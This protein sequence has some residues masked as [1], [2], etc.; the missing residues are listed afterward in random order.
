MPR[1][2]RG[3]GEV[4]AEERPE[5]TARREPDDDD[6]PQNP[7]DP[8]SEGN[9]FANLDVR[10]PSR[11]P[12][13]KMAKKKSRAL[14]ILGIL[15][16]VGFVMLA[17]CCGGG[18]WAWHSITTKSWENYT[19]TTGGFSA[20]FPG[21]PKETTDTGGIHSFIVETNFGREAYGVMY[22][23]MDKIPGTTNV[24]E[25][26][27]TT[28]SVLGDVR[29]KKPIKLNGH[30]GLEVELDS[31]MS[32]TPMI[33][34]DRVYLV[35]GRLFQVMVTRAKDQG[36]P[37]E[38]QKFL[39]SFKLIG[40]Y[41]EAA[42]ANPHGE[43]NP[44]R[45]KP[46]GSA[47]G[48]FD[49][50][51]A[52]LD[53]Y[54]KALREGDVAAYK[55]YLVKDANALDG[56]ET[57]VSADTKDQSPAGK[58]AAGKNLLK[59]LYE[60]RWQPGKHKRFPAEI[61]GDKATIVSIW[62][63]QGVAG[64][65]DRFDKHEFS[66]IN[67]RWF[68]T[69]ESWGM[70]KNLDQN[71]YAWDKGAPP[72]EDGPAKETV[73]ALNKLGVSADADNGGNWTV[74]FGAETNLDQ[75]IPHADK[76]GRIVSVSLGENCTDAHLARVARWQD[77][78]TLFVY[79]SKLTNDGLKPLKDLKKL[80]DLHLSNNEG[81]SEASLVHVAGIGSLTGLFLDHMK[82]SEAGAKSLG[83][84]TKLTYLQINECLLNDAA[85][86]HL[87]S[88]ANLEDLDLAGNEIAGPGLSKLSGMKKL[89]RLALTRNRITDEGLKGLAGL[90]SL[91][92]LNIDCMEIGDE[93]LVHIA[94]LKDIAYLNL[95]S[96]NVKG[97]GFKHLAKLSRLSNV[98]LFNL[99]DLTGVGL[100][101][102]AACREMQDL[103][104]AHTGVT[105]EG[106]AHIKQL[107]Q[108]KSL[109]LP[110]YGLEFDGFWKDPHPERFSDAGLKHV[111]QM[112]WLESI[113][114]SGSGVTDAGLMEL[115]GLARLRYI[116]F[117]A[118]PTV[119][120]P[121]LVHLKGL[122]ELRDLN[123]YDTGVDDADLKHVAQLKQITTLTLPKNTTDAG[124]EHL[125]GMTQLEEVLVPEGVT[126]AG[127]EKLKKA[128]PK[129]HIEKSDE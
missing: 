24:E 93:G 52:A 80:S 68:Q 109:E 123:L 128:L 96:T 43:K 40:A 63:Y 87:A 38:F 7:A 95:S 77:L 53:A 33:I 90:T 70:A 124:L 84:N 8:R 3:T 92:S 75:A 17:L 23:D 46:A 19:S 73:A 81:L 107:Q 79:H 57:L 104:L 102:L 45:E 59:F 99:P 82:L 85:L 4:P 60:N 14:L 64:E 26:L 112:T 97:P 83:A 47:D 21:K 116:G 120:G 35:K 56:F 110:N 89:K 1:Q 125:K 114:F 71:K 127:V 115:S 9:D 22:N 61:S 126:K 62:E 42:P 72:G 119:K 103:N 117:G 51:D 101:H 31:P 98:S 13:K 18:Y 50:P 10:P 108:I 94:G 111:A 54:V 78:R 36:D 41:A 65:P 100:E 86:A 39:D 74:W 88:L 44:P 49:T 69:S 55:A 48:G 16:G 32:G 29:A 58:E 34:T 15:G 5:R 25:V 11:K 66:K 67:G 12:A 91:E 129:A 113:T 27:E 37:A 105:N 28:A 106:L 122:S 118:L 30:P 6:R 121:G 2:P 20:A 76:L